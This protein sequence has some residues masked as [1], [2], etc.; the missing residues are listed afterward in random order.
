MQVIEVK[1]IDTW[2]GGDHHEFKAYVEAT[3]PNA[4]IEKKYR[5][6]HIA[7]EVLTVF[8]SLAELDENSIPNLRKSAYAKLTPLERKAIGLK[9]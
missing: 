5:N 7:D 8:A 6:C 9:L 4:E 2:D 3:V 1:R